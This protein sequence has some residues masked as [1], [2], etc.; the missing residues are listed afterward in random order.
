MQVPQKS[1]NDDPA[2]SLMGI[3]PK[4][5]KSAGNRESYTPIFITALF[6]VKL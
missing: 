3:Y 5:S 1:K 4:E 6:P 2:M